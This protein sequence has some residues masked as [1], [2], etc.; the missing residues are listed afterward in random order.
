MKCPID[1]FSVKESY[2]RCRGNPGAVGTLAATESEAAGVTAA[3]SGES[4]TVNTA[5]TVIM[6]KR[7]ADNTGLQNNEAEFIKIVIK[8]DESTN[9][10]PV[11]AS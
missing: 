11:S 9:R 10:M 3:T 1:P 4:N 5:K 8:R 2:C 7:H 6:H